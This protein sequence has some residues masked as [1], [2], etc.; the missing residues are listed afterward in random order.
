MKTLVN[1]SLSTRPLFHH[2]H[3]SVVSTTCSLRRHHRRRRNLPQPSKPSADS[4]NLQLTIDIDYLSPLTLQTR[5]NKLIA[6]STD[7]YHDLKTLVSVD[8]GNHIRI[9]CRKSTVIFLGYLAVWGIVVVL[10]FRVLVK[11]G[12]LVRNRLEG[13]GGEVVI[14][15][16]DRSLG[17]K[18]VVVGNLP[19]WWPKNSS[20]SVTVVDDNEEYQRQANRLIRAIMDYRMSGKDIWMDDVVQLRQ[21]CRVSGVKVS[22][23]TANSRDSLYR[24]AVDFVLNICSSV[25][26]PS[27]F[28][29]IIGEDAREFIAGL[30]DNIVLE[31]DRAARM[32]TAAVAARTRSWLLQAWALEMQGKHS[33]AVRELSK[34]SLTHSI[35]PPEES[36][37]E[38]EM[39]ARGLE[40]HLKVDQREF[41]MN[42]YVKVCGEETHRSVAEALGLVISRESV[43]DQQQNEENVIENVSKPHL[44]HTGVAKKKKRKKK[45]HTG[46]EVENLIEI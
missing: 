24:T 20:G 21:I 33:E 3:I 4:N 13:R 37:P 11:L 16:R 7:A 6:S 29:Q 23:D 44:E 26:D 43:Y 27:A 34:L 1:D 38:M 5:L 45:E 12:G 35:F 10:G 39:V 31:K 46:I 2:H 28:V 25:P 36:S 41:L 42:M 8:S 9:S 30:A 22:I 18:E 14:T 19:E 40:K 15:R 32:V 17:G